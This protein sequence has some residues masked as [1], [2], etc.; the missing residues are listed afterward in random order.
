MAWLEESVDLSC[1]SD[2]QRKCPHA[3]TLATDQNHFPACDMQV[4]LI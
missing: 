3:L 1:N 4:C 2:S